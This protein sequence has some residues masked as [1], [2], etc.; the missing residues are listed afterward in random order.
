MRMTP[1]LCVFALTAGCAAIN[2]ESETR[3]LETT[4]V[5]YAN[6]LRWGDMQQVLPFIDPETLKQ[7]PL[8]PLEIQRFKQVRVGSYIE[9]PVTPVGQHEVRQ[10]VHIALINVNTQVEREI[11]DNQ[12]WRYDPATKHWHNVSGLPDITQHSEP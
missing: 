3:A 5:A 4:L 7:H 2:Q 9:Q 10:T 8:T 6:A 11:I 1:L 12:L